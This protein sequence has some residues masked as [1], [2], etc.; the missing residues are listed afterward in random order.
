M[1]DNKTKAINLFLTKKY[2]NISKKS[3]M[4]I[5]VYQYIKLKF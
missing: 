1:G 2:F 4:T 5:W 3:L